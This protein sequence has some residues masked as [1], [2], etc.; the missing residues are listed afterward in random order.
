MTN[1]S[2]ELTFRAI[3]IAMGIALPIVVIELLAS[4]GLSIERRLHKPELPD[5][6]A[7]SVNRKD[8]HIP[9]V[10]G[11][12]TRRSTGGCGAKAAFAVWRR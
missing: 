8:R 3:A 12:S 10:P 2:R 9:T 5:A 1:R 4:A 6:V 11:G 7:A